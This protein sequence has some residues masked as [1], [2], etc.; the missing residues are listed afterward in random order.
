MLPIYRLREMVLP[1]ARAEQ[2]RMQKDLANIFKND[3]DSF[4]F[5][6]AKDLG[7]APKLCVFGAVDINSASLQGPLI[8]AARDAGFRVY[9]LLSA[10]SS[11]LEKLYSYFGATEFIYFNKYMSQDPNI[12]MEHFCQGLT[13]L[14]QA[15]SKTHRGLGCGR[16]ALSTFLRQNRS[17]KVDFS[18][19]ETLSA[20]KE[21]LVTSICIINAAKGLFVDYK[22]DQ[23]SFFDRGYT[24]EGELFEAAL[25]N[26]CKA[27][28][29]N[30]AHRDNLLLFKRYGPHN[31]QLHPSALSDETWSKVKAAR[32]SEQKWNDLYEELKGCYETGQWFSEVGTQFDKKIIEKKYV[33]KEMGL[34]PDKKT[35]V[36]FSHIF[37][38]ATFFWGDDLF[39]DY[40][41]WFIETLKI[42]AQNDHLNWIFK[43]HP[44]NVVKDN[45][46]G[47]K[48]ERAEISAIKR[49]LGELPDHIKLMDSE[50]DIST[51]SL[52]TAI[53]Y[54]LTVRG[55]IGMEAACFG[56]PVIT[57]GTGRY[58]DLGFTYDHNS[59]E[60]YLSTISN[61]GK[62]TK[63]T[64]QQI[65]L[66]RR[67]LYAVL[68]ERPLSLETI[69]FNFVKD[70]KA[71]LSVSLSHKQA[72]TD[73]FAN[74]VVILR[75]WLLSND[76]DILMSEH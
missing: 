37:W 76:D 69:N 53:D 27:I 25:L 17:G 47:F 12:D 16:Y 45:R 41:H 32:W 70:K 36:C 19:P 6:N 48:G 35:V 28:T 49:T 1:S 56:I 57:A 66:A 26:G 9:V 75:E 42:A 5:K 74:D 18:D 38:D 30:A 67:Y 7:K 39:E 51:F 44:A 22:F 34:D 46:D 14:D 52:F 72:D 71:T 68:I 10:P 40:E 4:V 54:C 23:I 2:L 58:D 55:T 60:A 50:H 73:S 62:L 15:M 65:E 13:N 63:M 61:L 64:E 29:M 20:F 43:S 21:K 3:G 8:V 11:K 33:I 31:T 59:R 24:P